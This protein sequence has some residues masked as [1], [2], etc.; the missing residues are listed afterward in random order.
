M[1]ICLKKVNRKG[2]ILLSTG[3]VLS[4]L[5]KI[6]KFPLSLHHD[7][8]LQRRWEGSP[9]S[10]AFF[11]PFLVVKSISQPRDQNKPSETRLISFHWIN[12]YISAL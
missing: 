6:G 11:V 3:K 12:T 8:D 4:N 9:L 10:A 5:E 2:V 7:T 1:E